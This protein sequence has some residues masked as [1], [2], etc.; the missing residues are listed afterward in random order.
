[1]NSKALELVGF[2]A[3][4][5]NPEGGVIRRKAG[6]QEPDGVLEELAFFIALGKLMP[7]LSV[8]SAVAMLERART[9][10]CATATRR[11]RTAG[12]RRAT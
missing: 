9:C 5:K 2:T 7:K 10:T 1:M 8:D 4:T 11:S 12:P 6:S 3:Q